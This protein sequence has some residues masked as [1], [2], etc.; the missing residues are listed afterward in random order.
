MIFAAITKILQVGNND[1]DIFWS[2]KCRFIV[3]FFI[4]FLLVIKIIKKDFINNFFESIHGK[5]IMESIIFSSVSLLLVLY[6]M[7]N[8]HILYI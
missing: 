4:P 5:R 8:I 3:L 7:L 2:S 6:S 1:P